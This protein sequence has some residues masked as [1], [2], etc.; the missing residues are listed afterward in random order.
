[1]I[2]PFTT[3]VVDGLS[4]ALEFCR[5]SLLLSA[6]LAFYQA[7]Q[8]SKL[9]WNL[10]LVA[11]AFQTW[12]YHFA[13][14]FVAVSMI[15]LCS[16]SFM[17]WPTYF[18]PLRFWAAQAL[19]LSLPVVLCPFL[20]KIWPEISQHIRHV[21]LEPGRL[22]THFER[23]LEKVGFSP[24]DI[25]FDD[26]LGEN[27]YFCLAGKYIVLGTDLIDSGEDHVLGVLAHELG[28]WKREHPLK[29]YAVL[30]V[31]CSLPVLDDR[32]LTYISVIDFLCHTRSHYHSYQQW[33]TPRA[34]SYIYNGEILYQNIRA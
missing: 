19:L 3:R 10:Q 2:L 31:P 4:L 14:D 12:H 30:Q 23:L 32:A 7:W 17:F 15:K 27:A 24:S 26:N 18:G 20:P 16:D 21:D 11:T 13:V 8:L 22:K 6:F 29:L 34:S 33:H 5:G 1:M 9:T 28:H 25:Y